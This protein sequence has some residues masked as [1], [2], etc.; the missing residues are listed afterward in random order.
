MDIFGKDE[1]AHRLFS[2]HQVS[3]K[4]TRL[5]VEKT[6]VVYEQWQERRP[7]EEPDPEVRG[8]SEPTVPKCP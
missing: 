6:G 8:R 3:E 1:R 7:E 2:E 5:V 4:C